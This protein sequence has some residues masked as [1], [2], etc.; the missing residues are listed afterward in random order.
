MYV[1]QHRSHHLV[2]MNK[3][4]KNEY[5]EQQG[6]GDSVI[7]KGWLDFFLLSEIFAIG[8]EVD[9]SEFDIWWVIERKKRKFARTGKVHAY[10]MGKVQDAAKST[11]FMV[12]EIDERFLHGNLH[13]YNYFEYLLET[14]HKRGR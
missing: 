9:F 4:R 2:E 10:M 5:A 13:T 8:F 3:H 1:A 11:K 7:S 6:I 14:C 12:M